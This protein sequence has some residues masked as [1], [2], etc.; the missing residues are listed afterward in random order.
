[1]DCLFAILKKRHAAAATV[2]SVVVPVLSAQR[3][4]DLLVTSDDVLVSQSCRVVIPP[5]T[6][7]EDKNDNG[8][9]RVVASNIEIEFAEGSIL[10]GSPHGRR[11]D[12]YGGY[13][14]RVDGQTDVVV[15]GAEIS[16]FWGGL[17]ATQADGRPES[18]RA[19]EEGNDEVCGQERE[20]HFTGVWVDFG[21]LLPRGDDRRVVYE[22]DHVSR[23][24][25][26][27]SVVRGVVGQEGDRE[28]GQRRDQVSKAAE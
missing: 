14:I 20:S 26:P 3:L 13:G 18:E 21:F 5:D 16:G 19:E 12:E 7:I 23:V 8:V 1:M 25:V 2:L 9:I 17:W 6:V 11:P 27:Y 10:R 22:R 4:P 24:L 28:P 15:R